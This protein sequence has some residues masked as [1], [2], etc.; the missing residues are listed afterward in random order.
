MRVHYKPQPC[1]DQPVKYTNLHGK[2]DRKH[3]LNNTFFF[4]SFEQHFAHSTI[5]NE[6]FFLAIAK[7]PSSSS[8]NLLQHSFFW[9]KIIRDYVNTHL[10]KVKRQFLTHDYRQTDRE[11]DGSTEYW[12]SHFWYL[13]YVVWVK[14]T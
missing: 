9:A 2:N 1:N 7:F 11:T 6:P 5:V 4:L 12:W 14:C 13:L 10:R 8:S 3:M